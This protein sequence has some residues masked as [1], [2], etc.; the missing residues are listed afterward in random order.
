MYYCYEYEA[1]FEREISHVMSEIS[2]V[3]PLKGLA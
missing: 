1:S 3:L 2:D